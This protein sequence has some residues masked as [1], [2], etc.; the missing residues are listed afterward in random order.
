MEVLGLV[1]SGNFA[2][3]YALGFQAFLYFR[4][5]LNLDKIRRHRVL[6]RYGGFYFR[7]QI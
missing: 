7:L 5:I 2:Q 1:K 6:R 3:A 4:I